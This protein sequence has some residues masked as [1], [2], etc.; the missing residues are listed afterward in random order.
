MGVCPSFVLL[1]FWLFKTHT[2]LNVAFG[3]GWPL[4]F[5]EGW[6]LS[7]QSLSFSSERQGASR[8]W[9]PG[10]CS[11]ALWHDFS[12]QKWSSSLLI[13]KHGASSVL[14]F[15]KSK[16]QSSRWRKAQA[17]AVWGAKLKPDLVTVLSSPWEEISRWGKTRPDSL[18]L[19]RDHSWK[20]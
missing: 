15:L 19:S 13:T 8:W 9:K 7:I 11:D 2:L 3:K 5:S 16:G 4:L 6:V 1:S 10:F 14:S 18:G 12:R 17:L 20:S